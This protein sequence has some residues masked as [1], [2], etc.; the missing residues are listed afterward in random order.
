M[1]QIV[2][3][4]Y[5]LHKN[6]II[7]RDLKLDNILVN[8]PNENDKVNSNILKAEVKL[9]DFGFATR[10]RESH[11]NLTNT[12]LGTPSNMEPHMLR[13]MEKHRHSITGY[14]EK[15]IYGLWELFV[16]KC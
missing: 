2:S 16:M 8:F 13:D 11:G 9:I 14:N 3:A 15:L 4:I 12:I 1:K 10:L 7:H 6:K 5:Y